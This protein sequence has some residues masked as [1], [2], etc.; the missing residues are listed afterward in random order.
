MN[1]LVSFQYQSTSEVRTVVIDGEPWFVGTDVARILGY[2]NP[3]DALGRIDADDR[4][5]ATL[6]LSEG[7]REVTRDRTLVNESGVFFLIFGSSLPDAV[8]FRRWI[9]GT[10]LP[11]IRRT[12]S[13]NATPALPQTYSEALRALADEF[14]AH[15]ITK[16]RVTELEAP[17]SAWDR[18]A[19]SGGDWSVQEAAGILARDPSIAIGR[20]RLFEHMQA[21]HWVFRQTG[22]WMAYAAAMDTGYLAHRAQSHVHPRTGEVVLDP[23]QVRV[24]AKGLA[25]LHR[26]LGG[27]STLVPI[28]VAS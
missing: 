9:T 8:A 4:R 2:A 27:T 10:V 14:E 28:G 16:T 7:S 18:L 19:A 1:G 12:G 15:E 5:T 26:M 25:R 6:A 24:T 23:P 13:Y 21:S 3:S 11:E 22:H 17:A 20:Q